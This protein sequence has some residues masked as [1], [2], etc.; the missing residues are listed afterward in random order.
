MT[1]PTRF[2][3]VADLAERTRLHPDTIRRLLRRGHYPATRYGAKWLLA[4][5]VADAFLSDLAAGVFARP[6]TTPAPP[7]RHAPITIVRPHRMAGRR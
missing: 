6:S 1:A 4:E 7:R 2:V 5:D 3:S